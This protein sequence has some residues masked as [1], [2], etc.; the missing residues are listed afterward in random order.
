[1]RT[2]YNNIDDLFRDK[3]DNF[4]VDPPDYV[5]DNIK[6]GMGGPAG[7]GKG[8]FLKGG[9]FAGITLILLS[10]GLITLLFMN[11][12][13]VISEESGQNNMGPAMSAGADLIADNSSVPDDRE[14]ENNA[15]F[16]PGVREQ[17]PIAPILD[18]EEESRKKNTKVRGTN[19]KRNSAVYIQP[20]LHSPIPQE[21]E[22][23]VGLTVQ[24][25]PAGLVEVQQ[26]SRAEAPVRNE[27]TARQNSTMVNEVAVQQNSLEDKT[28]MIRGQESPEKGTSGT[29]GIRS[30][31][32]ANGNWLFGIYFT[33]ELIAFPSDDV[34]KNYSY[35]VD[36]NASYRKGNYF[37]QSG[38]GVARNHE[39][40]NNV[41]DYNKYMGSYEDVYNVTFDSTANGIVP[42]YHT[43][44]VYVYDTLNHVVITPTKRYFTYLQV[45]LFVGYGAE[46]KQFGWF[47]KG[48]PSLSFLIHQ[49]IPE[50]GMNMAQ[51]RVLNVENEM[52]DRISTHW[53]FILSAG[54]TYKLGNRIS[55]SMEPM[56]RYYIRS[57][58]EQDKLNTKHPYSI[59]LRSGIVL[60]F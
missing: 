58:Y 10:I 13:D 51:A 2:K 7:K 11:N 49:Q 8:S 39:Q 20:A 53:Q 12:S 43:E 42:V 15:A 9:G 55:L 6:S 21:R 18:E 3:F 47:L 14:T 4:E 50:T 32:G 30:D 40:G 19:P 36:L 38:I 37:L 60:S 23:A 29:P 44:T 57:A 5:W 54:I 17:K 28:D 26:D 25:I 34:M 35:S 31:Y 59:G 41:I 56:F 48:G 27:S 52:P 16:L 33:P 46:S 1:M 45:P 22:S 24:Q